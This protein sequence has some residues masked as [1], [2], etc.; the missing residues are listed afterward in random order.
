MLASFIFLYHPNRLNNLT[1]VIRFLKNREKELLEEEFIFV[2]QTNFNLKQFFVNQKNLNLNLKNYHKSLM[3]NEGVKISKGKYVILLDSDRI[4]P[5]NYFY[6]VL[7]IINEKKIITTEKILQLDRHYSDEEIE[8]KKFTAERDDRSKSIEGRKKNLFAGNTV[9]SK[10][11][12][13]DLGGYDET[14]IG[15]GFADNDISKKATLSDLEV[16]W[17]DEEEIHLYHE[18]NIQWDG[19]IINQDVFKIITAIN[20]IKYYRKWNLKLEKKI[21]DLLYEIENN[22]E[23]FPKNLIEEYRKQ[24][25]VHLY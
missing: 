13:L 17:L 14:F 7:N 9:L 16:I 8:S 4:L 24:I 15:Y 23:K 19:K 1:Q 20:G 11:T 10:A 5:K 12:F 2:C 6:N 21:K 18:K 22:L 25:N 3:T